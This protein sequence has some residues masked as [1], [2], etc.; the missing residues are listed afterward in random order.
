VTTDVTGAAQRE[1][2]YEI[3]RLRSEPPSDEE[4]RAIQNYMAGTFV[5]QNSSR[6]GIINQLNFVDLHGVGTDY[7]RG[8]VE[9]VLAVTPAEIQRIATE[10][11]NPDRMVIVVVGDRSQVL[12]QVA[13]FGDL[14]E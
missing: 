2:F 5:L 4:L 11:L 10:Y 6:G 12:E 3:D 13:E 1:I 7:L 9:R 8:Y 14:V